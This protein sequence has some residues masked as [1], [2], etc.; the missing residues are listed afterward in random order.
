[1]KYPD[2]KTYEKLYASYLL[3]NRSAQ[4]L[5]KFQFSAEKNPGD[6]IVL[7]LCCGAGRLSYM[8]AEYGFNVYSVDID[9]DMAPKKCPGNMHVKISS[10][11]NYLKN[12]VLY[13]DYA[14]YDVIF[15]QQAINYWFGKEHNTHPM[16]L[17]SM[18]VKGGQF[19]F[20][21]FH[22]KPD[23]KGKMRSYS[24]KGNQY[25][26]YS[27]IEKDVITHV[28]VCEGLPP[29]VTQFDWISPETFKKKLSID[30][31]VKIYKD[32]GSD[33][34]VCTKR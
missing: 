6:I 4:M 27:Y 11:E 26:E 23:K 29:H 34:Y 8:C 22:N 31:K 16:V 30:F 7:D 2:S 5:D 25:F 19:I 1:M 24:L 13:Q 9:E 20:N 18:L 28:Q 14:T 3:N 12:A 15:C 21:T 17:A 33:L 10:V 32:G